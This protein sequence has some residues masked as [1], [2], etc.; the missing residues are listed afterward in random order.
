ML[1]AEVA[2]E[3]HFLHP[4]MN[5]SLFNRLD[6]SGLGLRE[7]RLDAAFGENPASTAGLNQQKFDTAFAHAI[8]NGGDLLSFFRTFFRNLLRK[9]RQSQELYGWIIYGSVKAHGSRVR[10][11]IHLCLEQIWFWRGFG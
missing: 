1:A 4:A 8:T 6:G 3:G 7:S 9:P 11:A 10:D 5:A 2:D